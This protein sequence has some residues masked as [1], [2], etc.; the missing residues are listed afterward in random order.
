MKP[1]WAVAPFLDL[2]RNLTPAGGFN[3]LSR[4]LKGITHTSRSRLEGHPSLLEADVQI[5]GYPRFQAP[6]SAGGGILEPTLRGFRCLPGT[7]TS[8][9]AAKVQLGGT[10]CTIGLLCTT[11]QGGGCKL[12][13]PPGPGLYEPYNH[14][15]TDRE[16]V[17]RSQENFTQ[18]LLNAG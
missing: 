2:T 11:P 18:E 9:P 5:E 12:C 4:E 14:R 17:M 15:R 3:L 13:D 8:Q 6:H 16:H 10:G 1:G 7:C